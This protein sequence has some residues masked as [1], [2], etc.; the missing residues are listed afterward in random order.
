MLILRF[1]PLGKLHVGARNHLPSSDYISG[2]L[3]E[4]GEVT[5]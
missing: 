2:M 1:A 3:A 5:G 4:K